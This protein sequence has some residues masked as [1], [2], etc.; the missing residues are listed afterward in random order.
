MRRRVKERGGRQRPPHSARA[1]VVAIPAPN[2]PGRRE[3]IGDRDRLVGHLRGQHPGHDAFG[4]EVQ[5]RG[6][7]AR[8]AMVCGS[9]TAVGQDPRDHGDARNTYPSTDQGAVHG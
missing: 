8:L 4:L 5:T 9:N 3:T 2:G 7:C 1:S 6:Q